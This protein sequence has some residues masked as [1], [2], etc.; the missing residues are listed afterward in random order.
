MR[1][2]RGFTLL[3]MVLTIAIT[4]IVGAMALPRLKA[5]A[6]GLQV[7]SA[8]LATSQMIVV[9]RSAAIQ[10]GSEARFIRSGNVVRVVIDSS[11]TWVTLA[12]KNLDTEYGVAYGVSSGGRDT[13]RYDARGIAIGLSGAQWLRFSKDTKVDSVC[14]S[15]MGKVAPRSC[16]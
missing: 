5:P 14:V 11:G 13:V 1:T 16:S 8:K 3:D 4:G 15:R 10:S 9:A 7:R 12:S 2:R 6:A